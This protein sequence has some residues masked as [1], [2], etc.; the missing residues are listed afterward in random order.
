V[1]DAHGRPIAFTLTPGHI[2]DIAVASIL[3]DTIDPPRRLLADKAYDTDA[4][5]KWLRDRDIEAVIPSSARRKRAYPL[6][7]EAYRRRNLIERMFC[8]LK[9]FRRV[10][11]RYDRLAR[12]YLSA[13]AIAAV[14]CFWIN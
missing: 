12:N 10:A 1:A 5:R 3:L 11:T 8:R 7:R 4:F 9:D 6:D 14:I 2:A 13:L